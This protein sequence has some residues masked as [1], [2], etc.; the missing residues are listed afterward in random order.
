MFEVCLL[1]TLV[2]TGYAVAVRDRK[3]IRVASAN[4]SVIGANL[5]GG[6]ASRS[7]D[8]R[9]VPSMRTVYDSHHL[10]RVAAIESSAAHTAA[11][12]LRDPKS[13]NRISGPSAAQKNLYGVSA[14][15]PSS[16]VRSSLAGV[17][18]PVEHFT[19]NNMTPF[20]G[21]T[22]RQNTT[23]D[24]AG[25]GAQLEA[26]GGS[27]GISAFVAPKREQTP[28]FSASR[29]VGNVC[30]APVQTDRF[31]EH[32]VAPRARNNEF[33][34]QRQNVGPGV[35]SFGTDPQDVYYE[36]R[37]YVIPKTVDDLRVASKPRVTFEARTVEGQRGSVPGKLGA[38]E[39]RLPDTTVELSHSD[40]YRMPAG[41]V[42]EKK[43]PAV[44]EVRDTYRPGTHVQYSGA[45]HRPVDAQHG[46]RVAAVQHPSRQELRTY[47]PAPGIQR[48]GT[49]TGT[50]T[51]H[52][53]ASVVPRAT[54]R[55][56]TGEKTYAGMV[57]SLFKAIVTP[58]QDVLRTTRK[59]TTVD[60]PPAP[61][62]QPRVPPKSTVRDPSDVART[63]L[64][65]TYVDDG[66]GGTAGQVRT[67]TKWVSSVYD[68]ADIA[69]TTI[70]ETGSVAV[71]S[72]NIR[73]STALHGIAYDPSAIA[74]TTGRET[75]GETTGVATNVRSSVAT[76]GVAYD[77]SDV[78][79]TTVRE[80][81]DIAPRSANLSASV[82]HRGTT[83]DP[84]S[85]ARTTVRETTEMDNVGAINLRASTQARGTS[86]DPSDIAR[87]TVRETM[88]DGP[89]YSVLYTHETRPDA[90]D[91]RAIARPTARQTLDEPGT[92]RNIR[93]TQLAL[94]V[95]DPD[96]VARTTIREQHEDSANPFGNVAKLDGSVGAYVSTS[97]EAPST[98]KETTSQAEHFGA[99][100]AASTD[101]Y[102]VSSAHAPDTQR[103]VLSDTDHYG[104]A[105]T[106]GAKA[107]ASYAATRTSAALTASHGDA[108]EA[109]LEGRTPTPS[110]A[111]LATGVDSI[112][113]DVRRTEA[114]VDLHE[115]RLVD[116]SD[117]HP[118]AA[119]LPAASSDLGQ[120]TRDRQVY[121][122]NGDVAD[123]VHDEARLRAPNDVV[124]HLE[125]L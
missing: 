115:R 95:H 77:P 18:I 46:A 103:Q 21:A 110:S 62:L 107:P 4:N 13:S 90:R 41:V 59:E 44:V 106:Q 29:D 122:P 3:Q 87:T 54:V 30:G 1:A 83:Y 53:R 51:D 78:A 71:P 80:T 91:P 72:A 42:R 8:A 52:G 70:R 114:M 55:A 25:A 85:V 19:H 118:P 84:S 68:P 23:I 65:E 99:A 67:G 81:S 61:A 6:A 69:R 16:S 108:R 33:P 82:A 20:F 39:K 49:G 31:S 66:G 123:R 119:P 27:I 125:T 14:T 113:L 93:A 11:T 58:I 96:H 88:I 97:V 7:V 24:R 102:R 9:R 35:A 73:A 104:S 26:F 124:I 79:R 43:R 5:S 117:H 56:T 74:R 92:E 36:S 15:P 2:G 60:A 75:T 10:D 120:Q 89:D 121:D 109:A 37:S 112:A 116:S 48:V 12:E 47:G 32:I 17:D 38:V 28:M 64:K 100:T 45:A 86:Y 50:R 57:G 40:L 22:L 111:S 98:L 94:Q 63:T 101:G 105:A 34:L 76:R